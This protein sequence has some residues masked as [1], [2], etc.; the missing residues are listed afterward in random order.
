MLRAPVVI[1]AHG[2]WEPGK[3][4]SQLDKINNPSDL[5]GFKAHFKGASLPP[6]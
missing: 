5:L 6:I 2:S 3:L 1:A 4:P